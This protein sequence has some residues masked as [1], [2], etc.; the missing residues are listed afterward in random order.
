MGVLGR[1]SRKVSGWVDAASR[2][3]IWGGH[4]ADEIDSINTLGGVV[5]ALALSFVLGLQYMVAPGTDEMQYADFR[6]LI[7]KSQESRE[8]FRSFV[9]DVFKVEDIGKHSEERPVVGR[10]STAQPLGASGTSDGFGKKEEYFN[11]TK[12]VRLNTY[13]D[14]EQ[15]L[16]TGV[17][18]RYGESEGPEKHIACISDKDVQ[19]AVAFTAAEFPMEYMRAFVL[20]TGDFYRW[21][22]VTEYIGGLSG[23]LIFSSLLWSIILNLSLALAPVREDASGTALVAWLMIGGPTM[24]ANYLF[25]VVG[26]MMFFFTHGRQLMALSPFAGATMSNTVDVSLFS[27]LL[28]IFLIGLVLGQ[29]CMAVVRRS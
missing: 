17:Q 27:I 7:C 18:S 2:S 14:I 11:F 9:I 28:P 8:E 16:R 4:N 1:K 29:A 22:K 24:F 23:S 6:S 21:S 19:T 15:L 12:M 25:L 13:M 26:L 3:S 5:S 10:R 20:Q